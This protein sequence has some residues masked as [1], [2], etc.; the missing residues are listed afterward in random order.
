MITIIGNHGS[1]YVRKVLAA[2]NLKGLV[3]E[4]D[5]IVPFYGGDRFSE[6][7]PLRRITVLIDDDLAI[8]DSTVICEYL[9]ERYTG[10][11][12]LPAEPSDRARARGL[13]EF[14][15]SRM[16]DVIVW[17]LFYQAVIGRAVFGREMD[18]AL[19]STLAVTRGWP[20]SMRGCTNIQRW[21]P[22]CRSRI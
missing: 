21:P 22:C 13:E 9:D 16:G 18:K 4:I 3:Y 10:P 5:P 14:A 7:S 1:P 8:H 17:K 2:L 15:D 11:A 6:I 20:P 12:L 19:L